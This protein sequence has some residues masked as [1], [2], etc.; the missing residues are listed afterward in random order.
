[1]ERKSI[2]LVEDNETHMA[3]LKEYLSRSI[4]PCDLIL[5]AS[6]GQSAINLMAEHSQSVDR[7]CIVVL[8]LHMPGEFNGFDVL[9]WISNHPEYSD[10]YVAILTSSSSDGD[11]ERSRKMGAGF[12]TKPKS[13]AGLQPLFQKILANR[14]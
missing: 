1:M 8:N 4:S 14:D 13:V 3:V 10:C 12:Y 11:R 9:E 2:L 6:D 5:T 7:P